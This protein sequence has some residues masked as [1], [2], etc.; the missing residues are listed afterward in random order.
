MAKD[1]GTKAGSDPKKKPKMS[2]TID[3]APNSG[4]CAFDYG[5]Y[6]LG[7][8]LLVSYGG[9]LYAGPEKFAS[10]S[11]EYV[12]LKPLNAFFSTMEKYS[13]FHE[14]LDDLDRKDA[15]MNQKSETENNAQ[16]EAIPIGGRIMTKEELKKYDGSEGSPG[17]YLAILGQ[18]F[19]VS[20]G[21][22]HYGQGGG[23]SFFSAKD[24]SRA[25]VTGEFNEEGL[26]EDVSGLSHGDIIGLKEWIEFYHKD[27]TYVGKLVGHFYDADGNPTEAQRNFEVRSV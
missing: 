7:V 15:Q 26:I 24:G 25:F 12:V 22:D 21:S 3:T 8:L 20:K 6:V 14:F 17:T 16:E 18:V 11:E 13:P 10:L 9:F 19:D 5:L 1:S 4:P 23:Y 2:V 27:Y